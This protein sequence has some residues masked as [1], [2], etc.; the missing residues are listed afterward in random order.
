MLGHRSLLRDYDEKKIRRSVPKASNKIIDQT[1]AR[2]YIAYPDPTHW[3]YTGLS[4]AICLVDDLVGNTFYFK[5]VDIAGDCGVIWDQ[6]L[7]VDFQYNQDRT[8]FHSFELEECLAGFLFEDKSEASHFFKRVTNR[9]KYASKGTLNNASA[10]PRH[11]STNNVFAAGTGMRGDSSG[12]V[13][14]RNQLARQLYYDDKPPLE[15]QAL[16]D[17]LARQ[18]ITEDMI[19][20]NTQFIKDFIARQGGPLVGLEPPL[21]R[22]FAPS[23]EAD[24]VA[25]GRQP[26]EGRRAPPPPPP[27]P[28]SQALPAAAESTR[29]LPTQQS[30]TPAPPRAT[31]LASRAS[32][33]STSRSSNSAPEPKPARTY[34]V[35]PPPPSTGRS[36]SNDAPAALASVPKLREVNNA[37]AASAPLRAVPPPPA[38]APQL[39]QRTSSA[40]PP[41]PASRTAPAAQTPVPP[42]PPPRAAGPPNAQPSMGGTPPSIPSR[43]IQAPVPELRQT[44]PRKQHVPAQRPQPVAAPSLPAGPRP[45]ATSR[46]QP[47]PALPPVAD[48][49][50]PPVTAQASPAM[51]PPPSINPANRA[52]NAVDQAPPLAVHPSNASTHVSAAAP[53]SSQLP[54]SNAPKVSTSSAERPFQPPAVPQQQAVHG[55]PHLASPPQ[56]GACPA[57]AGVVP[58]P[59]GPPPL[60]SVSPI[61]SAGTGTPHAGLPP[62]SSMSST[63]TGPVSPPP[64]PPPPA[65]VSSP[66]AGAVPQPPMPPP[67]LS[68]TVLVPPGPPPA[69]A[70]GNQGGGATAPPVALPGHSALLASITHSSMGQL[71]KTDKSHLD[72]PSVLIKETEAA[73]GLAATIATPAANN[74]ASALA[75]ALSQR[76]NKILGSDDEDERDDDWE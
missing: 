54:E 26:Q 62:L 9:R 7:F 4:G 34:A 58:P 41:P 60:A 28:E 74:M 21:P 38:R 76:K 48:K 23:D 12:G 33:A 3:T 61:S 30:F 52:A 5:L 39:P 68:T 66:L 22:R 6:E 49:P 70:K 53:P 44:L 72:R 46:L 71:R 67:A 10:L 56:P 13:R 16:Y 14:R 31:P 35:P 2:L 8:F 63:P 25:S 69:L 37:S 55:P 24:S 73:P 51:P 59:P 43:S 11:K 65:T 36:I 20:A 47:A 15:W 17:D 50:A 29:S 40:V 75:A 1:V 45:S 18:G 27:P 32:S 57:P 64:G 19:A 42:P